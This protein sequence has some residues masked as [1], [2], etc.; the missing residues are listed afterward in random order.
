MQITE[1][2]GE[3]WIAEATAALRERFILWAVR[4]NLPP[5]FA[6]KPTLNAHEA[7]YFVRGLEKGIFS[8][9]DDGYVQST[10][11]PLSGKST[12][13]KILCLF[14]K[15]EGRPSLFREGVCQISTI[16]ALTLKH[17]CPMN[18]IEMEPT[19]TGR[20]KH[21]WAVDILLKSPQGIDVAF[22][23]VKRDD[24][25]W[26]KL[27][28]D[29]EHCCKGGSYIIS[30]CKLNKNHPKYALCM[31]IKPEYFMAVSPGNEVCFQLAYSGHLIETAKVPLSALVSKL[32]PSV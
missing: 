15:R 32:Q 9:D 14:W 22:C 2:T 24:S 18:Q 25:E 31:D 4:A 19:F 5:T 21:P 17:G 29:F 3:E 16:S 12:R 13:N 10:V 11:L 30:E 8:I 23:E 27:V 20:S 28:S 26:S 7:E 1:K 6:I